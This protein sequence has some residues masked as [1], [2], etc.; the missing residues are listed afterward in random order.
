MK[1]NTK[2]CTELR[3]CFLRESPDLSP[4][5]I[6]RHELEVGRSHKV[7]GL[8]IRNDLKWNAHIES[9]VSKASKRLYIIRILRRGGVPVEDLLSIYFA[10]IR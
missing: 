7:L 9:V 6:D 5:L 4:L 1:L 3:I 2:K 10:L 8:V